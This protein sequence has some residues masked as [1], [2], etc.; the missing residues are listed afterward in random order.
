MPKLIANANGQALGEFQINKDRMVIGSNAS[1]EIHLDNV[2]ADGEHAAITRCGDLYVIEDLGSANGTLVHDRKISKL[3]LSDQDLISIGACHLCFVEEDIKRSDAGW[4]AHKIPV[5]HKPDRP[6]RIP[7]RSQAATPAV[8]GILMSAESK[9]GDRVEIYEKEVVIKRKMGIK[10][11]LQSLKGDL[12][13]GIKG[14]K[15]IPIDSITSVQFKP[16]STL[17]SGYIKFV[18]PESKDSLLAGLDDYTVEFVKRE[19]PSFLEIKTFLDA[20][21]S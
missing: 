2:N 1:S 21:I 8:T 19:E 4:S 13:E 9:S 5:A 11:L 20:Q 14:D 16:A 12:L 17:L 15:N 7:K 6:E 18:I 10:V 3:L